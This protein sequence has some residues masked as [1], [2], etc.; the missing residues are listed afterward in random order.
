MNAVVVEAQKRGIPTVFVQHGIMGTRS[1]L[2]ATLPYR[3][4]LVFH[5]PAAEL[6]EGKGAAPPAE[7]V[8][9]PFYDDISQPAAGQ[10]D[11]GYVLVASQPDEQIERQRSRHSWLKVIFAAC[12]NLGGEV[13]LKIHPNDA[14]NISYYQ[15]LVD[16]TGALARIVRHGE[17]PLSE[18][19]AGCS[20][21]IS[22]FSTT[23]LDAVLA[24][25][26]AIMVNFTGQLDPYPFARRG[27]VAA[28]H[29]PQELQTELHQLLE[30]PEARVALSA[31]RAEY[32]AYHIGPT[33]GRA[34]QRIA[35]A[36]AECVEESN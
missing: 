12:K 6:P 4:V 13:I 26:P 25:K 21:F 36:L 17:Q 31:A 23:L 30:E 28:A 35:A 5:Q 15:Q 20:L 29:T 34:A 2:T 3:R 8:G 10:R 33:D 22:R 9:S 14:D 1:A 7:I 11:E 16:E 24:G 19:I 18:L 27:A 32:I